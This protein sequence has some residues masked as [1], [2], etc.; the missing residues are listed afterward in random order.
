MEVNNFHRE[1]GSDV[2]ASGCLA[3]H[4]G[5]QGHLQALLS[6]KPKEAL[7]EVNR[8]L[9]EAASQCNLPLSLVGKPGRVTAEQLDST[10]KLFR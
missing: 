1:T 2:I 4:T 3:S 7:M 9:V 5:A 8:Q 10:L 6:G